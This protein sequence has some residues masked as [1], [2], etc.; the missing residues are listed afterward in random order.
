LLGHASE[1]KNTSGLCFLDMQKRELMETVFTDRMLPRNI[2]G[3]WSVTCDREQLLLTLHQAALQ[4]TRSGHPILASFTQPVELCDPQRIFSAFSRLSIGERFYWELPAEQRALVGTGVACALEM[5]GETR[6]SDA[7]AMWQHIHSMMV[8]GSTREAIAHSLRGPV[9]IGGF[10]FD[11]LH[12]HTGL[13]HGFP[14]GSFLLPR[15]LFRQQEEHATLTIN[16]MVQVEEDIEHSANEVEEQIQRLRAAVEHPL[17]AS[18]AKGGQLEV[19]E[20]QS[21]EMWKAL[22][23]RTAQKIRQGE[24]QKVVLA[25]SV[26]VTHVGSPFEVDIALARLRKNYPGAYVFVLQRGERYFVGATPERLLRASD[27]Q[28]VTMALAGSAPRGNTEEE[29]RELGLSLLQ[30]EKNKV[31][32]K[33]VVETIRDA[34]AHLC[35][36]VWIADTPQLLRL[37]NIQHLETPV[38]GELRPG[39]TILDAIQELHPTPAVGGFPRDAA[40]R[41]IREHEQLDRGWYAGPVGWIDAHSNGEFAVALR[42]ALID[43]NRATLFAGCGIVADSTPEG[44]LAESCL[45]L[46]VM[47]RGLGGED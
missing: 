20:L 45:K 46:A 35:T 34:L 15:L 28:I 3:R 21:A 39:C 17:Q 24:F 44:E 13:W 12:S 10:A 8:T 30:S 5:Q 1:H 11:P 14:D 18:S 47:Q 22:V 7:T 2:A 25:R 37:Q 32:H 9:L 23:E 36:H 6:F 38:T 19:R 43:G 41:E 33:I 40:L 16:V 27:G 29:D 4:A 42:S 31:E 26:Q